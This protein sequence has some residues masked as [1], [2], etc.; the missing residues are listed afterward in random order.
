MYNNI[1]FVMGTLAFSSDGF[2]GRPDLNG[3]TTASERYPVLTRYAVTSNEYCYDDTAR[4]AFTGTLERYR[5]R[6]EEKRQVFRH[7]LARTGEAF[8]MTGYPAA[9]PENRFHRSRLVAPTS[10]RYACVYSHV[11]SCGPHVG[12]RERTANKSG[13][14][15]ERRVY[16]FL[17]LFDGEPVEPRYF[18]LSTPNW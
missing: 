3:P 12:V 6:S 17:S 9:S 18:F 14:R 8:D 2:G 4:R 1:M 13:C 10:V 16:L 15:S 5:V 11:F 7:S